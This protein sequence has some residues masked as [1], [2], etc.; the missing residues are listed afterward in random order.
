MRFN[1]A[2]VFACFCQAYAKFVQ[3]LLSIFVPRRV[4][5]TSPKS[6]DRDLTEISPRSHRDLHRAFA[7]FQTKNI[8]KPIVFKVSGISGLSRELEE[9]R[10]PQDSPKTA[11]DSPEQAQDRS[12]LSQDSSMTGPRQGQDRSKTAN[13]QQPVV[14]IR[15]RMP[16]VHGR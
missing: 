12:K 13:N 1:L 4:Q 5:R 15:P 10:Q 2:A 6:Q 3:S 9:P 7:Y 14:F 8:K 11:Q 16:L